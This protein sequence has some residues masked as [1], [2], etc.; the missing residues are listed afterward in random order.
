MNRLAHL[1]ALTWD[2]WR[3][4]RASAASVAAR[5]RTRLDS[6]VAH[7]RA[8]SPYYRRLY[9]GRPSDAM[10]LADLPITTKPELMAHFDEWVTD[11]AVNRSGVTAFISDP[12]R[13]GQLFLGRYAVW[14]TSGTTGRP[15]IFL[16]DR[17]ALACYQLSLMQRGW[18]STLGAAQW[19]AL[20]RRGLRA[21]YVLATG[22][23]FASLSMFEYLRQGNP[24]TARRFHAI[25]VLQPLEAMVPTL[26]VLQPTLVAGYPSALLLLAREQAA[27]RLALSPV[28]LI[29]G[30]ETL[31]PAGQKEIEGAFG[32]RVHD[33]YGTSEFLYVG[34][35]CRQG[36]HHVNA[37]W[38][39]LEPVDERFRPVPAGAPSHSVLLTNLAN[40]IQPLIRYDLGDSVTFR[41]GPCP[42]G[43]SLPAIRVE[44]RRDDC[45]QFATAHGQRVAVLPMAL[46]TVIE[47]V[48]GVHRFQAI[49][50]AP[51][52]LSLRL[53]FVPGLDRSAGWNAAWRE[54]QAYLSAQG[55]DGIYVVLAPEP[56]QASPTSGKFRQVWSACAAS[57]SPPVSRPLAETDP[58]DV[59]DPEHPVPFHAGR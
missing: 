56:P 40:R 58:E 17:S 5:Q 37:D 48:P 13:V 4:R 36:W 44:G 15:G 34:F 43:N 24:Y 10:A 18:P 59:I 30:G 8:H 55:L 38:V 53:E 45:L 25:S 23:H 41:V 31:D 16:H 14:T 20:A 26:N 33:I 51:D 7:A 42:C 27:G 52:R 57:G 35:S 22:G 3:A 19:A 49:Q 28:G 6:L 11:P 9:G 32:C 21:A 50:T 46:A 47:E 1:L 39:I 12:A 54:V 29:T 2:L